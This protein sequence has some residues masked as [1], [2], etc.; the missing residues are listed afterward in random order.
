MSDAAQILLP[1][2]NVKILSLSS[3]EVKDVSYSCCWCT[4]AKFRMY[5]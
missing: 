3:K 5:H 2:G 4:I 1:L